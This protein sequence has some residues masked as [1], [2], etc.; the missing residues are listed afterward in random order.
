MGKFIDLTGQTFGRLTIIKRVEK[1]DNR[2]GRDIYWLCGCNCGSG[3]K[4]TVTT[5]AIK[6]GNTLS[7]G[8]IKKE[9]LTEYNTINK[10]KYNTYTF[11]DDY[12]IGYTNK[13]EPFYF[14][15]NNYDLIK[16]YCWMIGNHGYV[17]TCI[18]KENKKYTLLFHRLITDC[19]ENMEVDHIN[20]LVS[21]NDNRKNNL[22]ICT[23]QENLC[24]YPTPKNN[25]SGCKG[26]YFCNTHQVWKACITHQNKRYNL[27][28]YKN[29]E[30]AIFARKNAEI[31]FFGEFAN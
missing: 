3:K 18:Y 19:P 15:A 23:H 29:K 8:C 1:P 28:S 27:G 17:M 2:K 22:R 7:C 21:R 25:K 31:K 6:S 30:D 14:D 5:S 11:C 24:N 10:K 13:N 4:I 20:G 9:R 12:Y 26:V 16:D